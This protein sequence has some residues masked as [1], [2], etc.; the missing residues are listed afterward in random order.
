MH[1]M[2][3]GMSALCML[4]AL[5]V[6]LA[7]LFGVWRRPRDDARQGWRALSFGIGIAL[8]CAAMAPALGEWAHR[9]LRGHMVQ[10]LLLGMFAPIGLALGAPMQVLMRNLGTSGAR[11]LVRVLDSLPMRTLTHPYVAALLDIGGM[12]VLYLTPLYAHSQHVPLLH[13]L[14]HIH[15]LIS[16]YLFSWAIAGTD[17][18]PRRAGAKLRLTTLFLA[19]ASHAVL[20]KLMYAHGLPHGTHSPIEEVRAAAQWMYYGGDLAELL[21][22]IAFFA[23][24]VGT[25][26]ARPASDTANGTRGPTQPAGAAHRAVSDAGWGVGSRA[27]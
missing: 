5:A 14:V 18:A 13:A 22:T 7:Y 2:S 6:L 11:R 8:L 12:Y 15:F 27:P 20:A 9:A 23:Q 16:G 1:E 21:L 26:R 10:H 17:P 24:R 19:I 3:R 25:G 4:P